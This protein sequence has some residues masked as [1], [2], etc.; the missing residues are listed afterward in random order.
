MYARTLNMWLVNRIALLFVCVWLVGSQVRGHDTIDSLIKELPKATDTNKVI[1]LYTIS[2]AYY[3]TDPG[4]GVKYGQQAFELASSLKW[5]KG[6]AWAFNKMGTNYW[7]M[8]DYNKA[9]EY[10]QHALE[11]MRQTSDKDGIAQISG[12]I[13]I[14]YGDLGNY[15]KALD[16]EQNAVDIFTESG[17]K[18]GLLK[19]YGNM[20]AVYASITNYAKALELYFKALKIAEELGDRKGIAINLNNLGNAYRFQ[21]NYTT[22]LEYEFK[23]LKIFKEV[24]EKNSV[25]WTYRNIGELYILRL[26]Y[27]RALQ[28]NLEALDIFNEL[29][30]Q[31]GKATMLND[32]GNNY[33]LQKNYAKA[34]E[35]YLKALGVYQQY[36]LQMGIPYSLCNIGQNHLNVAKSSAGNVAGMNAELTKAIDYLQRSIKG[37]RDIGDKD[38]LLEAMSALSEAYKLSGDYKKAIESYTDYSVLRDSVYSAKSKVAIANLEIIRELDKKGQEM[39]IKDKQL[40]VSE[41][42]LAKTRTERYLYI[43]CV[44]LLV[45]V[46]AFVVKSLR[47]ER[48]SVRSLSKEKKKNLAHIEAQ[49]AV[50]RQI[51]FDQSHRIR[52]AVVTILGLVNLFNHEDPEDPN[53]KIV[54]DGVASVT[55]E[56]DA[57]VK[58]VVGKLNTVT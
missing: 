53:N 35:Y 46:V 28:Y 38:V 10:N 23:A 43:T 8:S 34:L 40:Q 11:Y 54:I 4:Q 25:G 16:Y 19:N 17:N 29:A 7:A 56:L 14:V 52:G 45:V 6:M 26:E 42:M 2:G 9:L 55:K 18:T 5:V 22:A 1:L 20:G 51:A 13:G 30:D 27:A 48:Q 49:N 50:L 58:D 57:I 44:V 24:D 41:L 33:S 21:E 12:N 31:N 3:T 37:S 39:Q 32:I 15:A 36:N 47:S